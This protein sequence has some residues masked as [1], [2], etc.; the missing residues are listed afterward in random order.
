MSILAFVNACLAFA[1]EAALFSGMLSAVAE[2][3]AGTY[4]PAGTKLPDSSDKTAHGG[5]IFLGLYALIV[6]ILGMIAAVKR[7]VWAATGFYVMMLL[8]TLMG[9]AIAAILWFAGGSFN[10]LLAQI[11]V[12]VLNV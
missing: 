8:D 12:F 9:I 5:L 6:F 11:P 7:T 3:A 1:G 10:S 4:L 2:K